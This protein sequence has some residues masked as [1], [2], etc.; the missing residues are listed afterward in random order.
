M[1][2][3]ERDRKRERERKGTWGVV[4]RGRCDEKVEEWKKKKKRGCGGGGDDEN[5]KSLRGAEA[6]RWAAS[7]WPALPCPP[8]KTH[9]IFLVPLF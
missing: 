2:E 5:G 1:R 8:K 7:A 9:S 6:D 3:R 4:E